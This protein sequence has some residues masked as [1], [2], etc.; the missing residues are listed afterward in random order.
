MVS[1]VGHNIYELRDRLLEK[2]I[3]NSEGDPLKLA[4]LMSLGFVSEDVFTFD[5]CSL[6]VYQK[7]S[8]S[9]Y[10]PCCLK[11]SKEEYLRLLG[12][13]SKIDGVPRPWVSD[14]WGVL[15]I[16]FAADIID[17]ENIR[18][19]FVNWIDDFL[20][21]RIASKR[22]DN[23]ELSIA[24]YI[25]GEESFLSSPCI[26]LYL[27][28]KNI[29][30]IEDYVTKKK[31]VKQFLDDFKGLY[32]ADLTPIELALCVYVFDQI[33]SE[34]SI[35]PPN[36]WS[37]NDIINF[38]E[39][40]PTGLKRWTWEEKA[41]TKG[42][43]PRKWHIDNEY[44]VQNLLYVMLAPIFED[45]SDEENLESVGQK[46]PRV[47]LYLPSVHT[48]IE[49]KYRKNSNKSFSQ[50]I[51]EIGED[52]SLYRSDPK[53]KNC[54]LICFLWDHT[55]S[56]QEHTKFKEGV[57]KMEGIQGCVVVN[58]PSVMFDNNIK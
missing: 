12:Q 26:A 43:E 22:L 27:N 45:I 35:V 47:D 46:N 5:E 49:V 36:A 37:V 9:G 6:S 44:H 20:P 3:N 54:Q 10:K 30:V 24:K 21:E 7:C 52:I 34:M 1:L 16:K 11:A 41:R 29:N 57:L 51:G 38:L 28:Y 19:L 32:S 55:C 33:N 8:I 42:A 39:G 17:D 15:G 25:N 2:A 18:K 31:Y 14:I 48:I 4:F 58:S 40:I 56:T 50:F 13:A 23:Y 53:Y